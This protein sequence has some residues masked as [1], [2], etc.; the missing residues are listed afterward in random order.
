MVWALPWSP[1]G[2][3]FQWWVALGALL[4]VLPFLCTT[5]IIQ[6]LQNPYEGEHGDVFN[7][8]S[9]LGST[10]QCIFATLRARCATLCLEHTPSLHLDEP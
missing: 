2:W 4:L 6:L 1:Q 3:C 7:V 8:D 9:L 5:A 10:E